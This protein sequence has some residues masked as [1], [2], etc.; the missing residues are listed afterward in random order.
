MSKLDIR[1]AAPARSPQICGS[2]LK[3]I[4]QWIAYGIAFVGGLVHGF[5]K[6]LWD[7]VSGLVTGVKDVIVSVF[8]GHVLSDVKKLWETLRKI[9]WRANKGS[10]Q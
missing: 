10:G 5:F 2:T 7:A 9:T 1:V 3:D 4:G 8:T 6:S